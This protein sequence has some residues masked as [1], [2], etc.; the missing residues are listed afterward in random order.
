M[1]KNLAILTVL[2]L[3]LSS[4]ILGCG[5]NAWSTYSKAVEKTENMTSGK[6]SFQL[7]LS[8]SGDNNLTEN[9]GQLMME[10]LRLETQFDKHQGLFFTDMY[11]KINGMGVDGKFYQEGSELFL[12]TPLLPKVLVL[13]TAQQELGVEGLPS[14]DLA[15]ETHLNLA[16]LWRGFIT[17]DDVSSLGNVLLSTADGEVK[18]KKFTIA[19]T[20]EQL[21]P[22]LLESLDLIANDPNI[23]SWD[24]T[25]QQ[26]LDLSIDLLEAFANVEKWLTNG[27]L[28]NIDYLAFINRDNYIIEERAAVTIDL[29][30]IEK[31]LGELQINY[32]I[33]RWHINKEV[34]IDFPLL[35]TDNTITLE[36]LS[37]ENVSFNNKEV[38]N[39]D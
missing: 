34:A 26:E 30:S 22:I 16:D 35:T 39:H 5:V 32:T 33:N 36:N 25:Y 7:E 27:T 20:E 23:A 19:L 13:N 6:N 8:Y 3:L 1:Y 28:V 11:A 21:R 14:F 17:S 9:L 31:N 15:P 10:E 12:V 24:L 37:L 38:L 18:A 29:S 2:L 4:L